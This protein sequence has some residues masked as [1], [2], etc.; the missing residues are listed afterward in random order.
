M[1]ARI[2]DKLNRDKYNRLWLPVRAEKRKI[3][4]EI[5]EVS[6]ILFPGYFFI[7]T[8]DPEAVYKELRS[9]PNFIGI[10][11]NDDTYIPISK[12]EAEV[13]RRICNEDGKVE[14]SYGTVRDGVLKV[15]DGPLKGFEQYVTKVDKHKRK[16]RLEM[17]LFGEIRRFYM[18]VE[19]VGENS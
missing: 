9:F 19:M 18:G 3:H 5:S 4:G 16:V 6:C 12:A 11:K 7:E 2:R 1:Y 13:I 17:E 15:Y 14:M 8:D 10:L